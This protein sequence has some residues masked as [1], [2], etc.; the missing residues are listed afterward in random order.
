MS[1]EPYAIPHSC[2]QIFLGQLSEITRARIQ[3]LFIKIYYV[4]ACVVAGCRW[5]ISEAS[6]H[7]DVNLKCSKK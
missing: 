7:F 5:E 6:S 2:F 3:D 1:Q 4:Y